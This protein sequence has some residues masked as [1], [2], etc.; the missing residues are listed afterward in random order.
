M[1]NVIKYYYDLD[2]NSIRQINNV[3]HLVINNNNYIFCP[4][5][6]NELQKI[7]KYLLNNYNYHQLIITINNEEIVP[8]NNNYYSLFKINTIY[9]TIDLKNIL[10]SNIQISYG[11]KEIINNWINIWSMHVDYI[12]EQMREMSSNYIYLFKI[13]NYYIGL[14]ENAIQFLKSISNGSVPAYITHKRLKINTNLVELYNPAFLIIDTRSRDIAEYY[15]DMFFKTDISLENIMEQ[16]MPILN[17]YSS[18]E[19][20]LFFARMIYPTYFFDV[21]DDILFNNK[22]E[23][24]LNSITSKSV[25]YEKFIK[26]LFNEIKKTTYIEN[27]DWLI[28]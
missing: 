1:K 11:D 20:Q 25:E 5:N 14:A 15:K 18:T 17:N 22:N 21:Y 2:I 8:Y 27:I 12:E 10:D 6:L 19:K 3:F 7:E 24:I 23:S 26:E 9:K 28:F 16:I 13:A 4:C